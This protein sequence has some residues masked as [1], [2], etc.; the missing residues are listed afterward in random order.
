[1]R[2]PAQRDASQCG[3]DAIPL[4]SYECAVSTRDIR[5][6]LLHQFASDVLARAQYNLRTERAL[7]PA[8]LVFS[9]RGQMRHRCLRDVPLTQWELAEREEIMRGGGDYSYLAYAMTLH[10]GT[11]AH[12]MRRHNCSD[13]EVIAVCAKHCAGD[14]LCLFLPFSRDASGAPLFARQIF[15]SPGN[16]IAC[17]RESA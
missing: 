13:T 12:V 8:L 3:G 15:E 17:I 11:Y 7:A 2:R 4:R 5:G 1:M 16:L 9:P 14:Q 10:P 6:R